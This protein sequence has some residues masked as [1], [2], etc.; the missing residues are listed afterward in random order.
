M[1]ITSGLSAAKTGFELVRSVREL[2]RRPEID[3]SEVS[4]RL[5]EL[6]E[7]M[8]DARNA[9]SEAQDDQV[10]LEAQIAQLTRM[11]DVGQDFHK[12]YGLYWLDGYPYC[13]VCWDVDRKPVRLSGPVPVREQ[14]PIEQWTC[15][16]HKQPLTLPWHLAGKVPKK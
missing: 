6:Q 7:L 10:A 4:A 5:V 3:A 8:L 14:G 15:P 1:S 16:L 13:A 12:E 2:V 9:L 11:A